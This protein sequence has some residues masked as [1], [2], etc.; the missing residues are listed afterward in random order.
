MG[1]IGP[2]ELVIQLAGAGKGIPVNLLQV[3]QVQ[4]IRI[5]KKKDAIFLP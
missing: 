5:T 1:V 3:G 4:G 2:F